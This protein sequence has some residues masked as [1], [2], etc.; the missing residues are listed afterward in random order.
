M[1]QAFSR[2]N[3]A[4]CRLAN[5][6]LKPEQLI[7]T[8]LC[9]S[10]LCSFSH[11]L[12]PNKPTNQHSYGQ[13][14]VIINKWYKQVLASLDYG[15][16]TH[17]NKKKGINC[18]CSINYLLPDDQFEPLANAARTEYCTKL[19][20]ASQY[21]QKE[22]W[23]ALHM[24]TNSCTQLRYFKQSIPNEWTGERKREKEI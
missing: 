20:L 19:P 18:K 10:L 21:A 9:E 14:E 5:R 2:I 17:T 12:N 6:S 24:P 22:A 13:Y 3:G 4:K 1:L 8:T 7:Q 11:S 16:T 23:N 15:G